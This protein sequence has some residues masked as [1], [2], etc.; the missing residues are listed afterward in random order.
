MQRF[1][2]G[3]MSHEKNQPGYLLYRGDEN[4][5]SYMGKILGIYFCLGGG[6]SNIFVIFT[7]IPGEMIQFD[8]HIF[9]MG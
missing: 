5:P 1:R 2:N 7:P 8:E 4:L 6:N 3:D 9:Q